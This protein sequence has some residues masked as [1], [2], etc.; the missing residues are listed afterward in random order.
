MDD[1]KSYD[2]IR[3]YT[4]DTDRKGTVWIRKERYGLERN[5]MDGNE[6]LYVYKYIWFQVCRVRN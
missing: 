4:N 2:R 5:G 6:F 3:P 1:H